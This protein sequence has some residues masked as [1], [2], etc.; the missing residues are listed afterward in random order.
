[1]H[2]LVRLSLGA[3]C[4]P[5]MI[6]LKPYHR[7]GIWLLCKYQCA[8]HAAVSYLWDGLHAGHGRLGH[9]LCQRVF[10]WRQHHNFKLTNRLNTL[11]NYTY[12]SSIIVIAIMKPWFTNINEV[13]FFQSC[14]R[15]CQTALPNWVIR[16]VVP[17]PDATKINI[18]NHICHRAWETC[19]LESHSKSQLRL[20][21]KQ[22]QCNSFG[23]A[24]N[25][26]N[27]TKRA[28]TFNQRQNFRIT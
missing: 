15:F 11:L 26:D 1:M 5:A 2:N 4:I 25:N 24:A 12:H 28:A 19:W 18:W 6:L 14:L 10:A 27:F 22:L 9:K 8:H 7:F 23:T 3:N 13:L 16:H 17:V 20:V 21:M